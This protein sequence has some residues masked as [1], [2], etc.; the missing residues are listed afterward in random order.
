MRLAE[1]EP[2]APRPALDELGGE[3]DRAQRPAAPLA[4]GE[5]PVDQQLEAALELRAGGGLRQLQPLLQ[6]LLGHARDERRVLAL[7]EVARDRPGRAEAV[8][9]RR[10]RELRQRAERPDPEALE[11]VGEQRHLGPGEQQRDGQRGQVGGERGVGERR[12][13]RPPGAR[14]AGGGEG[15]E[16]GRR[17]TEPDGRAGRRPVRAAQGAARGGE[18]PLERPAV[19]R[20]D[21]ARGEP[22]GAGRAGLDRGADPLERAQCASQ[23]SATPAGSGATS[24]SVGQRASASPSRS[25]ARRP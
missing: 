24:R 17:G 22:G 3:D 11:R 25:P 18:D 10:A 9:E 7:G 16:A 12:D 8:G 14:P 23:A 15:G 2:R 13:L 19:Q 6:P 5:Q 4:A 20:A 1:G 21:P